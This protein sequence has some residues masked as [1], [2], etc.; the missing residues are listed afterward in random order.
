[1]KSIA[2]KGSKREIVGKASSKALRNAGKVPCVL[3]GG[4]GPIHFS[5]EEKAFK[6]L[7]YTPNVHTVALNI[8]GAAYNAILQDTQF[9]PVKDNILHADFY[10]LHPERE[11]TMEIPVKIVGNSA[12]VMRGGSFR[13]NTRFLTVR[14]IPAHLPDFIEVDIT[15]LNVGDKL[16]ITS[17]KPDNYVFLNQEN[18]VICYVKTSRTVAPT[19]GEGDKDKGKA[20]K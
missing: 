6:P 14:A 17:L 18:T 12:G 16:Y 4:E 3:Y 7:V 11:I 19:E 20:K 8:D 2:I 1:M 9:H 13:L 10:E 15:E 5:A